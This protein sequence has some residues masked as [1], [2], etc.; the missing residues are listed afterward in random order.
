MGKSDYEIEELQTLV[1][2]LG[3][4]SENAPLFFDLKNNSAKDFASVSE[5]LIELL[6]EKP[7]REYLR[8][9]EYK[10]VLYYRKEN[11]E[12]LLDWFFTLDVIRTYQNFEKEK[13]DFEE[14][15]KILKDA[16]KTINK[17]KILSED[18]GFV[19]TKLTKLLGAVNA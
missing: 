17:I 18:S 5:N 11:F 4:H 10:N 2:I 16:S 8:V 3:A 14:R 1:N 13:I 15:I 7:V 9:N 12:E 6:D 19:L